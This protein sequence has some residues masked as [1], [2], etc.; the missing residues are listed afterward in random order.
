MKIA[1]FGG[2]FNPV[3]RGHYEIVRH[4]ICERSLDKVIVVPAYRNPLKDIIPAIPEKIRWRLLELT[5]EGLQK[6][7]LSRFELNRQRVSFTIDTVEHFRER[8][9]QA[10]IHL[11]LGEDAFAQFQHWKRYR[12]ILEQASILLFRRPASKRKTSC[13][14]PEIEE[15]RVDFLGCRIS[16]VSSTDIRN[17]PLNKVNRKQWIHENAFRFWEQYQEGKLQV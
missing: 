3:H 11:V 8:Y 1:I 6:V 2:S 13:N 10:E 9:P 15:A 16:D 14:I 4:L 7:E 5:F 17:T 12:R